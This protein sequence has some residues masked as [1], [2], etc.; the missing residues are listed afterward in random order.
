MQALRYPA[1]DKEHAAELSDE[2][3][4]RQLQEIELA[5]QMAEEED[6]EDF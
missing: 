2:Q 1:E 5:R 6:E 3:R 4:E